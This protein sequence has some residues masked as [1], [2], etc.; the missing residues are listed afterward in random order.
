M[1]RKFTIDRWKTRWYN[2]NIHEIIEKF[3]KMLDFKMN[4]TKKEKKD[5]K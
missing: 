1:R 5:E 2:A 3:N 4:K